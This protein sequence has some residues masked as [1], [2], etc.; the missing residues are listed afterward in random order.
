M[1]LMR[2]GNEFCTEDYVEAPCISFQ[3]VLKCPI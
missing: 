2:C 3:S 1:K